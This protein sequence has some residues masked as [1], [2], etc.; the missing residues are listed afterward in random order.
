ME[1][2]DVV[3]IGSGPGG[4]VAAIRAAQLGLRTAIVEKDKELGGTCLNIGCIP[5]KALL[6]SSDHFA[7]AK[8][9]ASKHGIRIDNVGLDLPVML[10]RK[11][12]VVKQLT[13][14]VRGLMKLNKVSTFQGLGAILAAGKVAITP[15]EGDAQEIEAKHI[16]IATGSVPVELPTMKFDGNVVVSSTEALSFDEVPKKLLVIGGGAIGLEMGSVWS[17]LG[18]EV[19]VLEFLPRIA[20]GFDLEL[21]TAL[22]KALTAQG[23]KFHLG[24]KV[25]EVKVEN[26][27]ATATASKGE[28]KLTF[29]AD[30]VLVSVG[31]RAFA[32][33]VG[34][35]KIGVEL[36]DRKRIKVDAHFRTNIEGVYAI[37]DVI[38]GPMLA[39]KAEEE[40]IACVEMIA[41][42]AGHV[43]YDVIPGIIYTNPEAAGV[44][45][46]EDFAKEK[47][48]NVRVGKF[49]FAANGRA[50][51]AD[52]ATGFVKFVAD[53]ETDR[54]IG[55]HILSHAAS[56]LMAEC[57]AV[58]EF[59]GSAED[60]GR[61]VH[62]HP[63]HS[64]AVKEAALAVNKGAIHI[65]N[66]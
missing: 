58:M 53:A 2:F 37:G 31:R 11:D 1:S 17:R 16:I 29:D 14:G 66:R 51:A 63:T 15:A 6:S 3:I 43:N 19:T 52:D 8:K 22:Q 13:G 38:A 64:E 33:G 20:L 61:T 7:F 41:G 60:L 49:P 24:T 4:Y 35:D 40:G 56:D 30:K 39:H 21:A 50:L 18:S 65:G 62:A 47:G 55:A 36:D 26:G 42:K 5:S 9:E 34:A 23:M 45:I 12:K 32:E 44:G 10:Q 46:T 57:V 54:I 25:G 59:G 48:M 28:D 27:R